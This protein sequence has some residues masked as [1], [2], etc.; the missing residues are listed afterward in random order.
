MMSTTEN[1]RQVTEVGRC[2]LCGAQ[3][4]SPDKC[5][6]CDWVQGYE[7]QHPHTRHTNPVDLTACLLSVVPGMGHYYKGHA[8]MAWFYLGGALVALFFCLLAGSA[9]AGFGV[10]LFPLYWAWVMTHAYWIEDLKAKERPVDPA[11]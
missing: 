6:K 9:S 2:P 3:L 8:A 10:L 11:P 1:P 7:E 4:E 5:S